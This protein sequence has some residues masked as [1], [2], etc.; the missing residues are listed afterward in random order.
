MARRMGLGILRSGLVVLCLEWVGC[1]P[2]PGDT[3][4][5]DGIEFQWCPPGTFTMGSPGSEAGH[6]EDEEPQHTVTLTRGFWL[7]KYEVTQAQWE[8]AM[9]DNPSEFQNSGRPVE[10]VSW[11]DVQ[12]FIAE[13]NSATLF[14][15]TPYRLPTE[16]EWEYACRAGTTARYYWGND[17]N[18]TDIDSYA[19]HRGNS[20]DE[21]HAVGQK[22][23]NVWGLYDMSGN[24]SEW[25]Q[26]WFD[27]YPDW[28]LTDPQGPD[29]GGRRVTR[30]AAWDYRAEFARSA[31]RNSNTPD[32]RFGDY[33]F[34]LLRTQD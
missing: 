16:A 29:S 11:E 8:R 25:C 27:D 23:P 31:D 34:R 15:A 1:P 3:Q 17:L 24:V 22:L 18:E 19:W 14:G 12:E 7:G 28:P 20:G 4:V 9:G 21:T 30:G 26:D 5:F 2:Q 13:L 32:S 6:N 33:G 10:M